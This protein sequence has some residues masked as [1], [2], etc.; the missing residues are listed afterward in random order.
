MISDLAAGGWTVSPPG[1]PLGPQRPAQGALK[2]A[3]PPG[4]VRFRPVGVNLAAE[5]LLI[6]RVLLR[7]QAAIAD[8][9]QSVL[10]SRCTPAA[11]PNPCSPCDTYFATG[12][13]AT[14][15]LSDPRGF[16]PSKRVAE[17]VR[18]LGADGVH[19]CRQDVALLLIEVPVPAAR[20]ALY[21]RGVGRYGVG[22]FPDSPDRKR[23]A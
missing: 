11:G 23:R 15:R 3:V 17:I 22:R 10:A 18:L 8:L 21:S 20:V 9:V 5:Q 13:I 6:Y 16:S 12:G 19:Q 14:E 7:D 2:P 4:S 1:F